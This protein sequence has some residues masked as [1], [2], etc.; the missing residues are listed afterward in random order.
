LERK[1]SPLRKPI[2]AGNWKMNMSPSEAGLLAKDLRESLGNQEDVDVVVAPPFVSLY[3]VAEVLRGSGI[4]LSGQ[5]L[6]W[7]DKGAFT[8]AISPT[9]LL[10][11]GCEYVI[12][13]H[14]ERRQYFG[15]T[16][17]TVNRKVRAALVHGLLQIMCIGESLEQRENGETFKIVEAQLDGGLRDL[18][19]EA[20]RSMVIAY[21]P[22]WA[23]G[24]GKTATPEQA[25]EVHAFIRDYLNNH[26][27]PDVGGAV[28][29]QYGGSVNPEN[30]DDLMAKPDIDGALVGGA[31]LKAAN[32]TRIARFKRG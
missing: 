7:E 6:F 3:P 24:T 1:G 28:R 22:I 18:Q 31:S 14:S 16:D 32:F 13:G 21:E 27:G 26:F 30:I 10:D 15:E 25:Q 4:A 5:D 9:M 11:V 29:I 2:I 8:G 20:I 19:K 12:I 17:E 23:I